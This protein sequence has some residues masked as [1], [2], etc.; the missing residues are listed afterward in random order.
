M[1]LALADSADKPAYLP[2]MGVAGYALRIRESDW[3]EHP[4]LERCGH[5]LQTPCLL[6]PRPEIDRLLLFRDWLRSN[7]A[8]GDL[9][10]PTKRELAKRTWKYVRTPAARP[11]SLREIN[12]RARAARALR[13]K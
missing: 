12:A 9:Y 11:R 5:Q 2:T 3:Y 1:V 7:D 13:L 6:A 10:K 8:D 4:F